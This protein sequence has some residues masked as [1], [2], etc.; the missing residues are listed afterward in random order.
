M[1]PPHSIAAAAMRSL[2]PLILLLSLLSGGALANGLATASSPYLRQHATDPVAWYPWG[3]EAFARA[4]ELDRPIFLSIGYAAC[5][6]CHV[7]REESFADP[8]VAQQLN[9][10]FV[11]IK[12]DRQERPDLDATYLRVA[13]LLNGEAGWPL[14]LLLTPDGR[15]FFASAYLPREDRLGQPGLLTLLPRFAALWQEQRGHIDATAEM[16]ATL[17]A[18]ASQEEA[19]PA[20]TPAAL[21]EAADTLAASF[22]PQHGGFLPAPK[23]PAVPKLLFLLRYAHANHHPQAQQMVTTTLKAMARGGLF[24]QLGGGFH[25]YTPAAD[26]QVPHFE[27]M[28][29]DQALLT[30]VYLEGWQASGDPQLRSVAERTLEYVL[31]ELTAADGTFYAAQDADSGGAEGLY[32]LWSE[33]QLREVLGAEDAELAAEAFGISLEGNY[34]EPSAAGLSVPQLAVTADE[35]AQ[36]HHTPVATMAERL[37]GL[38]TQLLQARQRRPPPGLDP[39]RLTDWNGLMVAALARA[40]ITLQ[41][42]RYT[43]CA[44]RAADQLLTQLRDPQG[45]L[46]HR[47]HAGQTD[48]PAQLDDYAYLIW[49]LIELYE[50]SAA[51]RYLHAALTLT[52][53]A[54]QQLGDATGGYFQSTYLPLGGVAR[55]KPMRD[56]ATPAGN[57]VMLLNLLRLGRMTANS[58]LEQ[59]AQRLLAAAAH[60]LATDPANS[61]TLLLGLQY[62]TTRSYEVVL[63]GVP[64]LPG[65]SELTEAVFGLYEPHKVVLYR[66][67]GELPP[68]TAL[69]PYTQAQLP[70]GG[71]AT[72]YVCSHYLCRLPSGDPATVQRLL[73]GEE[74]TST[75]Q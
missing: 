73:R 51:P 12:V 8:L 55:S 72:A 15:P 68:I 46:W 69:A 74:L 1:L 13:R 2:L 4:R 58:E 29:Y 34:P 43:A 26:W 6:W 61:A 64:Q 10:H 42:P 47:Y 22:D 67:E 56:G 48:V 14:N 18:S 9:E 66:P 30:L 38:R 5:H 16:V 59:Q 53:R 36:R 71:R 63:A 62:A 45:Q 44:R 57:G 50:A 40:G 28:L 3:E 52:S 21:R 32:Y 54:Q 75:V 7:M 70:Q 33:A 49:G 41:Q 25:R 23:F 35:L 65:S 37:D 24:D 19:A 31:R 17:L 60:P 11:A 39:Q 27:K 20:P